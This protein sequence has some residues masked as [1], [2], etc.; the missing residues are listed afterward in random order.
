MKNIKSGIGKQ[1]TMWRRQWQYNKIL[2]W[3][4]GMMFIILRNFGSRRALKS[5]CLKCM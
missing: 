1:K 3:Y 4:N 2:I 5:H